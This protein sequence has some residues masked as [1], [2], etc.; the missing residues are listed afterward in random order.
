MQKSHMGMAIIFSYRN[1]LVRCVYDL[2]V[3]DLHAGGVAIG[4][5]VVEICV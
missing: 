4:G 1:I 5:Q 2:I 3:C